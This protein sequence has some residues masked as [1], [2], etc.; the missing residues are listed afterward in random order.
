VGKN[1][2]LFSAVQPFNK[3]ESCA[4]C[5]SL[6]FFALLNIIFTV[7][8]LTKNLTSLLLCLF[9]AGAFAQ[10]GY[11]IKVTLKPIKN[12]Y[13]YLGH[14]YGK[15]LPIIDSVLL[16]ENSEGV[17]RGDKVLGG[18]IYLIGFPDR[19]RNFEILIDSSRKFSVFA[20]TS[21]LA[22]LSFRNSPENVRFKAYQQYMSRNGRSIDSLHKLRSKSGAAD[23][24]RISGQIEA[25]NHRIRAYRNEIIENEPNSLL[26]ALLLAMKE[27][28]VPKND[29]AAKRD[30]MFAYKYF[31]GHYWDGVN[32]Y[33][34][35]LARTP[36]F[37]SRIDKYFETLVY[38]VPDS[39][40]KELD[41]MLGFA[42]IN[43]E[44]QKFLL[45]KFVNRYLNQKYMWEDAVFVHLYENYF[46]NKTYPW[47]T[48]KGKKVISDRYYN[49]IA[50]ITGKAAADVELPDTLNR[51]VNLY[52]VKADYIVLAIW[53]PTCGHCKEVIPSL[54]SAYRVKW[55]S[56]GVKLFGLARETD[57]KRKDWTDFI[58]EHKLKE[59]VHVYNSKEEDATRIQ[60]G[61]PSYAQLYD[62][63]SFPTLYL[64]DKDKR[65]IL[66]KTTLEQIDEVLAHRVKNQ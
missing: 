59:W 39:V 8:M 11:E 33:D 49:L 52:N 47:L 31:K 58:R 53:D 14:Y 64:L 22:E 26:S 46:S 62:V 44:M 4:L 56:M 54:D 21:K 63:Q 37:E 13:V 65:I 5:N 45:L 19:T 40:N 57:G 23:S 30:S 48:E 43:E 25:I 12:Q 24:I 9:T 29:P 7:T 18:G 1:T 27:P 60:S 34:D 6:T 2:G 42:S 35:R 15:Q 17:F 55:K 66:K 51:R 20:D 3:S 41:Y 61:I 28:E 50:N 10:G 16:N 32:F 36:F 38:P